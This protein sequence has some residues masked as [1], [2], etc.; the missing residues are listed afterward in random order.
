MS[1]SDNLGPLGVLSGTFWVKNFSRASSVLE[2]EKRIAVSLYGVG[3]LCVRV[4]RG[5]V[6]LVHGFV[7]VLPTVHDISCNTDV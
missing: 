3:E 1:W 6:F 7:L 4:I 2:Q 5:F